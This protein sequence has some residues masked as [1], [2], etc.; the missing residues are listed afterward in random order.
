MSI[1]FNDLGY[2]KINDL[3]EPLRVRRTEDVATLITRLCEVLHQTP[4]ECKVAQVKS[5][6]STLEEYQALNMHDL[7]KY[8]T[9]VLGYV[10]TRKGIVLVVKGHKITNVLEE[11]GDQI[12]KELGEDIEAINKEVA[13]YRNTKRKPRKGSLHEEKELAKQRLLLDAHE[14]LEITSEKKNSELEEE[15]DAKL[16]LISAP[17]VLE[18]DQILG[19]DDED[20]DAPLFLDEEIPEDIALNKIDTEAIFNLKGTEVVLSYQYAAF[21]NIPT[22]S[23]NRQI[24]KCLERGDLKEG[25]DI[26]T[27]TGNKINAFF[28]MHDEH[29][30]I[31]ELSRPRQWK[32]HLYLLTQVGVN[33]LSRHFN[34][35]M[36][37]A[38]VDTATATS[39][40][41]QDLKRKGLNSPWVQQPNRIVSLLKSLSANFDHLHTDFLD[42]VQM[43]RE[44]LSTLQ[45]ISKNPTSNEIK[46]LVETHVD[47]TLDARAYNG[48]E[49]PP[50]Y[51]ISEYERA[52]LW[53]NAVNPPVIN[54]YLDAVGHEKDSWDRKINTEKGFTEAFSYVREGMLDRRD[55][56]F[57]TVE[58]VD[59]T[60]FRFEF[61]QTVTGETFHVT[62]KPY[63]RK[64]GK[65]R[66][67]WVVT[68]NLRGFMDHLCRNQ[69]NF[70]FNPETEELSV[71]KLK[72][73]Q[74]Q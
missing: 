53:A 12:L 74:S 71:G 22:G 17:D 49:R 72:L 48:V 6:T 36:A 52:K 32:N 70:Q 57:Q 44:I 2:A 42:V 8:R 37:N 58:F 33:N 21:C 60:E 18:A 66:S 26:I 68:H 15:Q 31:E 19:E 61:R 13:P 5:K 59:R 40:A 24:K 62:R 4:I 67:Q 1:V 9:P 28:I 64:N 41:I 7:I 69:P 47:S 14:P 10:A 39:A 34:N 20:E 29:P 46:A 65:S 54:S 23:I 30:S 43:N 11:E 63:E 56:F 35:E 51:L 16:E 25:I 45:N 27:L 50:S 3:C 55:H 73:I 38:L